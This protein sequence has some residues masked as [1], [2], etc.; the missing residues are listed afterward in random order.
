MHRV[1]LKVGDK[2]EEPVVLRD[3]QT[4]EMFVDALAKKGFR[5][6]GSMFGTYLLS[7]PL[8][9]RTC[10]IRLEKVVAENESNGT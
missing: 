7:N 3:E 4:L 5:L 8:D 2:P 9:K 6:I 10:T 1:L